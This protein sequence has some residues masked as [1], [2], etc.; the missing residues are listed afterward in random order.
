MVAQI[1]PHATSTQPQQ[2]RTI[3]VN[4]SRAQVAPPLPLA[5]MTL[6]PPSTMDHVHLSMHAASVVET[7]SL[8]AIVIVMATKKMPWAFAVETAA[9]TPMPMAFAMM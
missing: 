1:Q 7:A 6:H 3:H 8:R 9:P 2:T 5:I 4:L